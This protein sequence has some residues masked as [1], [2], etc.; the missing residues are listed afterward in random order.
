MSR[1]EQGPGGG[2]GGGRHISLTMPDLRGTI[3]LWIMGICGGVY[4]V[5]MLLDQAGLVS[6]G[7]STLVLGLSRVGLSKGW[8]WQLVTS[9]FLHSNVAHLVFN[10]VTLAFLGVDIERWLG[11]KRYIVFSCCCALAG[12]AGFLALTGPRAVGVGYSGVLYGILVAAAMLYPN[13]TIL[14]FWLFPMKMK[15][16]MALLGLMAL[17]AALEPNQNGIGH[18]AHLF[19]AVAGYAFIKFMSR[20]RARRNPPSDVNALLKK[21]LPKLKIPKKL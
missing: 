17:F 7:T 3:T 18:A 5:Q 4:V 14:I 11:R 9:P 20:P 16:A 13:R 8:I 12:S 2:F 21:K 15:W 1:Y 6:A 10:M 19:G